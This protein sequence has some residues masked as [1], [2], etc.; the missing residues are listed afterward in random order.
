MSF[1]PHESLANRALES[2]KMRQYL[3]ALR[4]TSADC[5]VPLHDRCPN[6]HE[7]SPDGIVICKR[8]I[9]YLHEMRR[10]A[11]MIETGEI[12]AGGH[13]PAELVS[14]LRRELEL[15]P[16]NS[17]DTKNYL[18]RSAF[19]NQIARVWCFDDLYACLVSD[20][21]SPRIEEIWKWFQG[22]IEVERAF[23]VQENTQGYFG[24]HSVFA[25]AVAPFLWFALHFDQVEHL[26]VVGM[27]IPMPVNTCQDIEDTPVPQIA[28]TAD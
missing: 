16:R 15:Y 24:A 8:V 20:W 2:F 14:L 26:S 3:A 21:G 4:M 7:T 23:L 18:S 27:R 19:H 13:N 11:D 1:V 10:R 5:A 17:L 25:N 6:C 12:D 9:S 22:A 28:R